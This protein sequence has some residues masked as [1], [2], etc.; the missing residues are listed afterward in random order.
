MFVELRQWFGVVCECNGHNNLYDPELTCVDHTTA[1]I[2]TSV[3]ND[4]HRTANMLINLVKSELYN[5]RVKLP[6]GWVVCLSPD[7]EY[8]SSGLDY[9]ALEQTFIMYVKNMQNCQ[10]YITVS[11][12]CM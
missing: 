6:S 7:C 2:T 4:G 10:A 1:R 5:R 8:T 3:H 12:N 11:C 9:G